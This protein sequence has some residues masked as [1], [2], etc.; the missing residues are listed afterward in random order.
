[1]KLTTISLLT[2]ISLSSWGQ[3]LTGTYNAYYGHSLE[4]RPDSTF[5]YEWKFDLAS[6]W[7]TGQW[8][9]SGKKLYLNIKNVYDTLTREG[10]PDSLVLSSDEK[11][12]RIKGEELVVNLISGGGQNRNVD[13]ITDRLSIKGKRLYLMSKTG[14][15]LRTKESG[16]WDRRKRPTYYFRVE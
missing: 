12:N 4:L 5:R 16:I 13:R 6:S 10:K 8:R 14:Q 2:I 1:M 9:V 3:N 7:T 15:V 11:S